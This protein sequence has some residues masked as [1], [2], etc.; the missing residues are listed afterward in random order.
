MMRP[1]TDA[2]Y[3]LALDIQEETKRELRTEAVS[4]YA[5]DLAGGFWA[6]RLEFPTVLGIRTLWV[7]ISEDD[8]HAWQVSED[9]THFP[10]YIVVGDGTENKPDSCYLPER[11]IALPSGYVNGHLPEPYSIERALGGGA[12]AVAFARRVAAIAAGA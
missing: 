10:A 7:G 1:F 2:V 4:C 3:D 5:E 11:P 8:G 9:E 12:A 6:F